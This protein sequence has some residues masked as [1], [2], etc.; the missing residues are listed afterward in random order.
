VAGPGAFRPRE[1]AWMANETSW[2]RNLKKLDK[3]GGRNSMVAR[4]ELRT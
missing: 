1:A 2:A 4:S 3:I